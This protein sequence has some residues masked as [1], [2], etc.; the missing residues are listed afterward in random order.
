MIVRDPSN[1]GVELLTFQ[2]GGGGN[3]AKIGAPSAEQGTAYLKL[4]HSNDAAIQLATGETPAVTGY[5]YFDVPKLGI[6]VRA[7]RARVEVDL[8]TSSAGDTDSSG[9]LVTGGS[10]NDHR[11]ASITLDNGSSNGDGRIK[12]YQGS[13]GY[14]SS[15]AI[16][17]AY[18]GVEMKAAHH[19]FVTDEAAGPQVTIGTSTPTGALTIVSSDAGSMSKMITYNVG[20][21]NSGSS[22]LG[23]VFFGADHVMMDS[24]V[25]SVIYDRN[26]NGAKAFVAHGFVWTKPPGSHSYSNYISFISSIVD[27][28]QNLT[29]L[30]SYGNTAL[31]QDGLGNALC[32]FVTQSPDEDY[33]TKL[34]VQNTYDSTVQMG[35]EITSWEVDPAA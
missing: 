28:Q 14:D 33:S 7:P 16:S 18:S 30:H 6:G 22:R 4:F 27:N 31:T 17:L 10:S 35:Y 23:P 3:L 12:I 21:V 1:I 2:T 24:S 8:G 15:V 19:Y 34:T 5:T 20:I 25:M 13:A 11:L 32:L 9:I 29:A 26:V